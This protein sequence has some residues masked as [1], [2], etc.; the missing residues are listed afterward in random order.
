MALVDRRK[1][2]RHTI[3]ILEVTEPALMEK[4][5]MREVARTALVKSK[6]FVAMRE[7]ARLALVKSRDVAMQEVVRQALIKSAMREVARMALVQRRRKRHP[8]AMREVKA[9]THSYYS[10][11]RCGRGMG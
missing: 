6:Y 10:T 1:R 7:V 8:I 2:I 9:L 4:N 3:A 5:A 11:K